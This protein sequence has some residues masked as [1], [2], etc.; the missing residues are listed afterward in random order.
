MNPMTGPEPAPGMR[1]DGDTAIAP[2]F[3]RSVA[4]LVR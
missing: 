3:K 1:P 2:S 4:A